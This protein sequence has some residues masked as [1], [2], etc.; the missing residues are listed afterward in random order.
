MLSDK[1]KKP[2][3]K[4]CKECS[5]LFT[6]TR[7]IQPVCDKMECKI[8]YSEKLVA[9]RQEKRRREAR[10]E[11]KEKLE[12]LETVPMLLKKAQAAFNRFVRLR[13][14][15][16]PCICCGRPLSSGAVLTGGEYDAGH[17]RSVG[18]AP[19]LRFH[20]DNVHAQRKDCNQWGAG[21]AVDYRIGL[22]KRIGLDRVEALENENAPHKWTREELREIAATY[23][24]KAK[25]ISV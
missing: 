25:E 14:N 2:R 17:Y 10:K 15:G 5:C 21:R 8:S 7:G 3:L 19:Q 23:K 12:A 20:E 11:T 4:K 1:Q 18:S 13:D 9:K 24:R 16:K 22:I 6:P